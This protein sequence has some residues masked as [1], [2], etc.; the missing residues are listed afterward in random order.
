MT[1]QQSSRRASK[2]SVSSRPS[3]N[4]R[5]L[6]S[7]AFLTGREGQSLD[8]LIFPELLQEVGCVDRVLSVPRGSLLL[9]GRS[10]VGRKSSVR[11]VS[12]MHSAK[13]LT[14]KMGRNYKMS[15]F[16]NDLKTVRI[17]NCWVHVGM[18]SLDQCNERWCL[19]A[20]QIAGI[21]GEQV[22][23]MLEDHHV[24]DTSNGYLEMINSLLSGGEVSLLVEEYKE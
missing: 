13:L 17:V 12:A 4:Q 23:F 5:F 9:A 19:Q 20:M 22:I 21:D 8:L 1:G 15:N 3:R 18:N 24:V 16:K 11:I 7:L 14:L 10:G 6:N 2:F